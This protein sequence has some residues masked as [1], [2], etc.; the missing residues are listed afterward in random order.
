[1]K[2]LP[3]PPAASSVFHGR[4]LA[5]AKDREPCGLD[6]EMD[7]PCGRNVVELDLHVLTPARESRV[8]RGV[9]ITRS[10]ERTERRKPSAWRSG[11][12]NTSRSV[13][14]VSIAW[15]EN[16]RCAPRRPDGA[17]FH[18]SITSAE[19]QNVTSPRRTSARSYS[20]QFPTQYFVLC[21]G[22]TREF[23]PKSCLFGR[24]S[25]QKSR[26]RPPAEQYLRTNAASM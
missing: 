16:L 14:A 4:P 21:F 18:A 23:M 11:S 10:R 3:A 2:F 13:N 9:D 8:I 19:S 15:S 25:G 12:P 26:Q 17:G 6:D 22:C 7:R 24:H 5:F 20:C 1:M